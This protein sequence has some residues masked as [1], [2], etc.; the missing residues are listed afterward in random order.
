MTKAQTE[1]AS[2]PLPLRLPREP[3]LPRS[4]KGVRR[5]VLAPDGPETFDWRDL[6]D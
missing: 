5:S 1:T 4:E 6:E 2:P 3:R